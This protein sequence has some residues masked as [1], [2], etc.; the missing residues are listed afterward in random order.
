M[1]STVDLG[2]ETPQ[3]HAH[4]PYST[5]VLAHVGERLLHDPVRRHLRGHVQRVQLTL[6]PQL[7]LDA[8]GASLVHQL[9]EAS[10]G[11]LRVDGLLLVLAQQ[12]DEAVQVGDRATASVLGLGECGAL[13]S[14]MVGQPAA[15]SSC[16]QHHDAH[17]VGDRVVHLPGDA[18][19]L[20]PDG[21]LRSN[22]TRELRAGS[23]VRGVRRPA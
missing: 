15:D 11:G 17:G 5:R 18:V 10:E 13:P 9:H 7:H 4:L 23:A 6:R 3:P 21:L 19:T 20:C 1:T 2:R 16:L 22:L 12:P 14:E 8:E